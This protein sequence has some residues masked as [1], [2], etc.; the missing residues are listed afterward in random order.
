MVQKVI[1]IAVG[2]GA[3]AVARYLCAAWGQ[4]L[5]YSVFPVGT[6]LVNVLGCLCIGLI[7][8]G[9]AHPASI[10]EPYR[11][12]L[13]VGFLGGFTTFSAFGWETFSLLNDGQFRLAILNVVA[14]NTLGLM[15]VWLGYRFAQ[16]W[17]GA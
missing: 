8:G 17:Y 13:M 12:V 16:K 5:T 14:T 15:A 1:L 7:A 6:L 3:G 4:S 11:L 9:L 10:G 2:G